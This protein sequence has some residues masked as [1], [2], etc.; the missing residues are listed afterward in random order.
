MRIPSDRRTR[1][2]AGRALP[3]GALTERIIGAFYDVYNDLCYGLLERAY[4][5][6]MAILLAERGFLVSREVPFPLH[7]HGHEIGTYRADMIVENRVILEI[8]SGEV[9]PP[10]VKQ[11]LTNYLRISRIEVGLILLF[12]PEPKF[13][14]VV[15]SR[16]R[17]DQI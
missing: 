14:R 17:E 3:E 2:V 6:A 8:K 5:A 11:Q 4:S 16:A 9:F 15:R 7:Y 1:E 10:G 12:G 13:K